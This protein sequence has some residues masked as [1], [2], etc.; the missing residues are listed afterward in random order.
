MPSSTVYIK[1]L[2]KWPSAKEVGIADIDELSDAMYIP[3]NG[4]LSCSLRTV[5]GG[6]STVR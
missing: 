5:P 2:C 4:F 6:N 1:V 3:D